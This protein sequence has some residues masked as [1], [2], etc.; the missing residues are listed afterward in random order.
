MEELTIKQEFHKICEEIR[1][2]EQARMTTLDQCDYNTM[3]IHQLKDMADSL[4]K[5]ARQGMTKR[6]ELSEATIQRW[7]RELEPT[8]QVTTKRSR[9][10]TFDYSDKD[11]NATLD[12]MWGVKL[13]D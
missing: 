8:P 4:R 13:C 2:R 3:R 12:Q 11:I 9:L 10:D 5:Q 6:N 1:L 7:K